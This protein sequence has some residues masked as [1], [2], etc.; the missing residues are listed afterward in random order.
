MLATEE[1]GRVLHHFDAKGNK[2]AEALTG[3]GGRIE[4]LVPKHGAPSYG[5]ASYENLQLGG[6]EWALR[7]FVP[8]RNSAT[9]LS[10]PITG[11]FECVRLVPQWQS[12]QI[13]ASSLAA[14]AMAALAALLC[15]AAIFPVVVHLS[16]E[17]ER[18][19]REVLELRVRKHFD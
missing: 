12:Q 19:T 15:G 4:S 17:N 10:L 2:L 5:K 1:S 18:K 13:M 3:D 9:D 6:G 16:K 11:Y 8:L 14:A 7:V